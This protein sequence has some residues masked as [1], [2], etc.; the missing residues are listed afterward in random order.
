MWIP[1]AKQPTMDA[2]NQDATNYNRRSAQMKKATIAACV[3]VVAVSVAAWYIAPM[4]FRTNHNPPPGNPP[5]PASANPEVDKLFAQWNRPDSPGCS[6]AVSKNRTLVYERGYGMANLEAGV[7]ITPASVFH[8][9]SIAKQ[10]T[11][12]SI[13]LLA[14]SGKLS[15]DEDVKTYIAEWADHGSWITIRHLLTHTSG[16][17]DAYLL[18]D[19]APP[20]GE[21]ANRM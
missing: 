18:S 9:A 5:P 15:L 6:L 8:V 11:A 4:V 2:T 3:F 16:L 20:R 17:R 12:M 19:L 7:A 1:P 13:L 21:S 14:Q 10:F